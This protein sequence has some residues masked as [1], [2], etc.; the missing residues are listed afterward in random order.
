MPER[1][2]RLSAK[3][4]EINEHLEAEPVE[5]EKAESLQ[6]AMGTLRTAVEAESDDEH[7]ELAQVFGDAALEFE[8]SHPKLTSVLNQISQI[9][10]G[11]GI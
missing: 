6:N 8:V 9:L 4:D 10:A 1:R 3:L 2:K 7:E 11:A 5:S